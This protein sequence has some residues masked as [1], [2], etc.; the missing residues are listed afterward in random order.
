MDPNRLLI[1]IVCLSSG[2]NFVQAVVLAGLRSAMALIPGLILL[3]TVMASVLRPE[4]GGW[5]GGVLWGGLLLLP[6]LA[7]RQ[8]NHWIAAG[9]YGQAYGL[10]RGVSGLYWLYGLADLPQ[11]LQVVVAARRGD[12]EQAHGALDRLGK[13]TSTL[14]VPVVLELFRI[15]ARWEEC[16][17][18]IQGTGLRGQMERDPGVSLAYL[19]ALG[20]TGALRDL[21]GGYGQVASGLEEGSHPTFLPL[22]QLM[23]LA[24]C[25]Q[26]EAVIRLFEGPLSDFPPPIQWFWL[27]TARQAAGE[28]AGLEQEWRSGETEGALALAVQ[29]RLRVPLSDP[30]RVL[31]PEDWQQVDRI[32][33]SLSRASSGASAQAAEIPY[34]TYGLIGL[35]LGVF[36]LELA[37]GGSTNPETLYFL[38][39]L[40]PVQVWAGQWWR[41]LTSTM[42]HYGLLHLVMNM[43][44]LLVLGPVVERSLGILR[45]LGLYWGAGVG[46]MGVI[47]VLSVTG[48]SST[49]FVVGASGSIMGL[50]GGSAVIFWRIWQRQRSRQALRQLRMIWLIIVLQLIFDLTTPR[51][52][53]VGHSSGLILG[54]LIAGMFVVLDRELCAQE[55]RS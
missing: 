6:S 36:G 7:F 54:F 3:T 41:T 22:A 4:L 11:L 5:I 2:L 14:V 51:I 52:S 44:G 39:G 34:G 21:V 45:Y 18:W 38:G 10:A 16:L 13:R 24:F 48:L 8:I 29:R 15:T 27:R 37:L 46:S 19:R 35:N 1:W 9:R 49:D 25:G 47:T 40:D 32:S 31:G 12:L 55:I 28:K 17:S 26:V 23:V 53:V 42:L 30:Q 33:N 20:E 50:V 43:L